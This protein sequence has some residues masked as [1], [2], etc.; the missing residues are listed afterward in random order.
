MFKLLSELHLMQHLSLLAD[1][2]QAPPSEPTTGYAMQFTFHL[3]VS[4]L[5]YP[6][7]VFFMYEW[8]EMSIRYT[9]LSLSLMFVFMI[10]CTMSRSMQQA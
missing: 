7:K 4:K 6:R 2:P 8:N 1:T 10:S 5:T 3:V 9:S